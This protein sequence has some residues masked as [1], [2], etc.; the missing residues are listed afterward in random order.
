MLER[1]RDIH[2]S[3]R[4]FYQKICD[5]YKTSIDYSS[6]D[7]EKM[8]ELNRVVTMY[9]DFA[10]DQARKYALKQYE[11]Y[12]EHRLQIYEEAVVDELIQST[13]DIKEKKK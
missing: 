13:K 2:A 10:E 7:E 4:R 1:I 12:D 9:L 6:T 3:E 8:S 5:I 11:I